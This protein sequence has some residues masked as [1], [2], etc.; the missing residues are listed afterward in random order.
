MIENEEYFFG[1]LKTNSHIKGWIVSSHS[2]FPVIT[3]IIKLDYNIVCDVVL[4]SNS[5][6]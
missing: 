3:F 6:F 4:Y 1:Y 5:L 2:E